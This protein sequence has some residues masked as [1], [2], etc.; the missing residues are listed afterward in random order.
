VLWSVTRGYPGDAPPL[1]GREAGQDSHDPMAGLADST[2]GRRRQNK[3]CGWCGT[4]PRGTSALRY[5]RGSRRITV[6][7]SGKAA[8]A[9]G[10]VPCPAKAL[11]SIG[12]SPKGCMANGPWLHRIESWVWR[13]CNIGSAPIMTVNCSN[14][15]HNKSYGFALGSPPHIR[16]SHCGLCEVAWA[17][18][19]PCR[20]TDKR[21]IP[22][23]ISIFLEYISYPSTR[24]SPEIW[25]DPLDSLR[26]FSCTV[27]WPWAPAY[28]FG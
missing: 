24:R 18:H 1:W 12:S 14:L 25:C 28:C 8:V 19:A 9:W 4:M 15:L 11:G 26:R 21:S 16:A 17:E 2:L 7:S 6:A 13:N 22:L 10:S 27:L 5:G 23:A 20:T 3:P